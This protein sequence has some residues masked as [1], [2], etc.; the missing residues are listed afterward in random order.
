MAHGRPPQVMMIF[1][2]HDDAEIGRACWR[3]RTRARHDVFFSERSRRRCLSAPTFDESIEEELMPRY[4]F[5]R[6]EPLFNFDGD[7]SY[8]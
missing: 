8:Y 1:W 2:R 7:M 5:R 6:V 3:F 4:F